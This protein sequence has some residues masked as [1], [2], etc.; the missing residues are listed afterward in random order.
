MAKLKV[1]TRIAVWMVLF[2]AVCAVSGAAEVGIYNPALEGGRAAGAGAIRTTIEED[3]IGVSEFSRMSIENF[4]EYKV[5]IIPN[6]TAFGR[7]ED[8]RWVDNL[9]AYVA[10]AGGAVIFNHDAIGAE[11]SP[12]HVNLFPEIMVPGSVV[13]RDDREVI[14]TAPDPYDTDFDYL[15]GYEVGATARHMYFDRFIFEQEGGL[16]L[17]TDED[18]GKTVVGL[19]QVGAGRVV[20]NGL[21][22][23]HPETHQAV[24]LEGIDRD[25]MLSTVK[26][27]LAG[28]GPAVTDPSLLEVAAWRPE[29]EKA[30]GG[31]G[32]IGLREDIR[33][34]FERSGRLSMGFPEYDFIPWEF[35]H[36]RNIT[37]DDYDL[38]VI[39]AP[40]G[41]Q[42]RNVPDEAF[43]NVR[44]FLDGG[45]RAIIFLNH[46]IGRQ[47]ETLVLDRIGSELLG[48]TRD[49][50]TLRRVAWQDI[51]GTMREMK[52]TASGDQWF[53]TLAEPEA[54]GS[55]TAGYWYDYRGERHSPAVI[56]APFGYVLNI[57]F[58]GNHWPFTSN[59]MIEVAP[60]LSAGIFGSLSEEYAR[61]LEELD[62]RELS[63][64]G[65]ARRSSA[66]RMKR[67]A[68][69]RAAVRD[70][71]EANRLILDAEREL[72]KAYAV[73][74]PS[75]P[76]EERIVWV[77]ARAH[78]DPEPIAANLAE[79]GFTGVSL[80]YRPGFYPS[81]LD[82]REA[83]VDWM[84]KWVDAAKRHGLKIGA[85]YFP[86]VRSGSRMY[87]RAAAEDWRTVE[88]GQY[89]RE[90]APATGQFGV[91]RARPEIQE[92]SVAKAIDLIK[93]YP[94]DYVF[95]DGMRWTARRCFCDNCRERFQE[96]TGIEVEEWP[97]DALGV[98]NDEFM[99]WGADKITEIVRMASEKIDET[100]PEV[101]LG[102]IVRPGGRSR[103]I[104]EGQ[105][106]WEWG[107]YV[108]IVSF[109]Y[110]VPET[111]VLE[112]HF[113]EYRGPE[114]AG[115]D[116]MP[117]LYPGGGYGRGL[118]LIQLQQIDLQRKYAPAGIY[119]WHYEPM[120][121]SF[122]ELL[123]M[124]PFR[125]R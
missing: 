106:W 41:G 85:N 81:E 59:A 54:E 97:D 18:T 112:E 23:G 17:L 22:G 37:A 88:A 104:S 3:G 70:Y 7:N 38:L 52:N 50:T 14:V 36:M 80:T 55:E 4:L 121:D 84:Q 118:G 115:Y 10:E 75:V 21:Y 122:L 69:R 113:I 60:G 96:D 30:T 6:T 40:T 5:V 109:M 31:L 78:P 99:R 77:T 83:E 25:V 53:P 62:A 66:E 13:Y 67:A 57:N 63:R 108:D 74:M 58:Y 56:R 114:G 49:K 64:A 44:G 71:A 34:A 76:G 47:T 12:F 79:A 92:Y 19:G 117:C 89:G 119:Y 46:T 45:G 48:L 28:S 102:V 94:V 105:H 15:P 116:L 20:F 125:N 61:T 24:R 91:C 11:R 72:M 9:R 120:C 1:L 93:K 27:A 90:R 51:D 124:G 73:S 2:T 98:Y 101:K 111:K 110:Y 86:G 82:S 107:D 42:E 39:F 16:S 87:D 29:R 100:N 65:R 26:W 33:V 68:G 43:E 103:G 35:L 8:T 32:V 95:Y 123:K